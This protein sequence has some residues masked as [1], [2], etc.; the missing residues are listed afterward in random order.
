[1]IKRNPKVSEKNKY[2]WKNTKMYKNNKTKQYKAE[3]IRC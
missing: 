3:K 2:Q 1:M